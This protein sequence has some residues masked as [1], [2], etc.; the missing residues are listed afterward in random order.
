[1]PLIAKYEKAYNAFN[2]M[3]IGQIFREASSMSL[4]PAAIPVQ[5]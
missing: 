3:F 1:M 2:R 4:N 5:G